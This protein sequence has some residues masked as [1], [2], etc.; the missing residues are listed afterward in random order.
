VRSHCGEG[1]EAIDGADDR[2]GGGGRGDE[3]REV[4]AG[5]GFVFEEEGA[6]HGGCAES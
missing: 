4:V 6:E 2:A 5:G 3:V 1:G